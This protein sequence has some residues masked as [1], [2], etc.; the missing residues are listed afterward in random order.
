MG[1]YGRKYSNEIS[2][3]VH[4]NLLPN[5]HVYPL[6]VHTKLLPNIHVYPLEGGGSH[7]RR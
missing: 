3:K 1:L 5:I 7:Q 2:L 4:T 6:G